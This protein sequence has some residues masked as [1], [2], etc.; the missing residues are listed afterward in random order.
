MK[1][2]DQLE[3]EEQ[4]K[5][6][7]DDP[8]MVADPVTE[9]PDPPEPLDR[10]ASEYFY[11]SASYLL[12][13]GRLTVIGVYYLAT[14]CELLAEV[15]Q[16]PDFFSKQNAKKRG[17]PVDDSWPED[18]FQSI[19]KEQRLK[20]INKYLGWMHINVDWLDRAG[21]PALEIIEKG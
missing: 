18:T 13:K 3:H 10:I 8:D 5:D 12:K 11:K 19:G 15:K 14:V 20:L 4:I 16:Q 21:V 6:L 17:M 7:L 2:Q 9:L 1:S